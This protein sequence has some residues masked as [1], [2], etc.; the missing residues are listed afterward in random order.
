MQNEFLLIHMRVLIN[1]IHALRVERGR[2][3]LQSMDLVALFEQKL[4][5]IRAV[6]AS[7]PGDQGFAHDFIFTYL[8]LNARTW[9]IQTY[10]RVS[11]DRL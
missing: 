5:Q 6:L 4:G 1:M 11:Q 2:S 9:G 7:C 10:L 8:V 3:S